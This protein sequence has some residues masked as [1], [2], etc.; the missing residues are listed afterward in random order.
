MSKNL[1][2]FV[3]K[4]SSREQML[5]LLATAVSFPILYVTLSLPK[6]ILNGAIEGNST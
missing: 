5:L 6:L 3:W 1:F 4:H 2:S